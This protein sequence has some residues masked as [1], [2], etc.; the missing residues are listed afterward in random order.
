MERMFG[1]PR[2]LHRSEPLR[3]RSPHA[4]QKVAKFTM[5]ITLETSD[6]FLSLIWQE[7]DPT[8]FLT[9]LGQPRTAEPVKARE[10]LASGISDSSPPPVRAG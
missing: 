8:R 9:P 4:A 3:R 6:E 2:P 10:T 7:I 5:R 1:L